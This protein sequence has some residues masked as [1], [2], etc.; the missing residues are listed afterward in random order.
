MGNVLSEKIRNYL[1][2]L[3]IYIGLIFVTTLSIAKTAHLQDYNYN[4][5][6]AFSSVDNIEEIRPPWRSRVLSFFLA[7]QTL[8]IFTDRNSQPTYEEVT[9]AIIAYSVFWLALIYSA[10]TIFCKKPLWYIFGIFISISFAYHPFFDNRYY[11]WDLPILFIFSLFIIALEK[12]NYKLIVILPAIGVF[13]KETS[14]V[15]TLASLFVLSNRKECIKSFLISIGLYCMCKAYLDK[16]VDNYIFFT[17]NGMLSGDNQ[18]VQNF[19]LI[20]NE[21]YYLMANSMLLLASF[22]TFKR[23]DKYNY[24]LAIILLFIAINLYSGA[25]NETRIWLELAPI[26]IFLIH[27][28]VVRV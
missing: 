28:Q 5:F 27:R 14:V 23:K 25:I 9:F 17:P 8:W 12:Q 24:L 10:F 2:C 1:I 7:N 21:P 18:I 19:Q 6:V 16:L 15:L 11:P 13:F 3:L 22:L 26:S 4:N 20:Y